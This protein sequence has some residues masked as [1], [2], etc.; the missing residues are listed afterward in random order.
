MVGVMEGREVALGEPEV[1][2]E[3]VAEREARAEAERALEAVAVAH[4]D[5]VPAARGEGVCGKL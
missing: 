5:S 2:G 3:P 1:E 4:D